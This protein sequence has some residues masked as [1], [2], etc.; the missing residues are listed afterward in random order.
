MYLIFDVETGDRK[1]TDELL[2]G[3]MPADYQN[4]FK[5]LTG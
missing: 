4:V 3:S 5:E 1:P 2:E